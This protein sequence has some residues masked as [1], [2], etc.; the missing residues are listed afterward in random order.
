MWCPSCRAD[1][2]AELSTDNRRMLCARCQSE[3]GIA[4]ASVPR[5]GSNPR[6][7][8]TERDARELLARWSA[9]NILDVN[10][11]PTVK[12]A[13]ERTSLTEGVA[14]RP[15][16]R[17]DQPRLNPPAPSVAYLAATMEKQNGV[18]GDPVQ[19]EGHDSVPAKHPVRRKSPR[20][21]RLADVPQV[22]SSMADSPR[23]NDDVGRPQA[24]TV[25]GADPRTMEASAPGNRLKIGLTGD[26]TVGEQQ[27]PLDHD[28]I[29]REALHGQPS[30]ASWSNVAGQLCA[31]G[32]VGLLTCG[33]VL[34]MWSYFGGPSAYMPTGWLI[35]AV[36]QML[37]FLGVI[38]LISGGMEQTV[39]EVSWRIDHLAAE[40]HHLGTS[41]DTLER[42]LVR[43]R[44]RKARAKRRRANDGPTREA[45]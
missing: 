25:S 21:P 40:V 15:E 14:K 12:P 5:V 31:Y 44:R 35:A 43:A 3:L 4:A 6:A 33:T 19:E 42:E 41:L 7:V 39:A 37:L 32:G 34:V 36:G 9:Q 1:V 26:V 23:R 16:F 8:E 20:A 27:S 11:A 38:T 24:A 28:Q 30:R 22:A 17:F 13:L 29:V 2:A 45:A 10:P 18:V